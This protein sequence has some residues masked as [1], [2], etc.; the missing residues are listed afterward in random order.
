MELQKLVD[1]TPNLATSAMPVEQV[2]RSL[3]RR[4]EPVLVRRIVAE[5]ESGATTPSLC[6]TY[7][8]SK[9]GILRLLRDEGVVL[10]RQPLTSDQVELAKKMYESGQPIA[11]IAT[12][13]DTSYNNVRQRLIKEGVQLRPRGGSLAS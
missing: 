8:L 6:Q 11:A 2:S 9:T 12:R 4:L 13:L 7:G 5:Y 10:R 3:R 1:L